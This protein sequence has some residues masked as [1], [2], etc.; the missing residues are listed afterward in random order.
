MSKLSND[1][2][3]EL[4]RAS[5]Q[6]LLNLRAFANTVENGI[7]SYWDVPNDE[8]WE[9]I[10]ELNEA[11]R[12]MGLAIELYRPSDLDEHYAELERKEDKQWLAK[13]GPGGT[14]LKKPPNTRSQLR[15]YKLAKLY[16]QFLSP[17]NIYGD[18]PR[19]ELIQALLESNF[20]NIAQN[21]RYS[22]SNKLIRGEHKNE[23][24]KII[25]KIVLNNKREG[26]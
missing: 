18:K 23:L 6:A 12:P 4:G 10:I 11:L 16:H 22:E 26:S 1:Q 2:I 17:H 7:D 15:T 5:Q 19:E 8:P 14:E 9:H 21:N 20:I 3:L 24:F 25:N 13:W